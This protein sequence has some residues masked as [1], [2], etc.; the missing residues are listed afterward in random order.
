MMT[1]RM[2]K[3]RKFR[4]GNYYLEALNITN[5][6]GICHSSSMLYTKENIF[7]YW[8]QNSE[9]SPN[10]E[11]VLLIMFSFTQPTLIKCYYS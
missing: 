3:H 1:Q 8:F 11:V 10:P 6:A 4:R 2:N 7:S 9:E 5:L